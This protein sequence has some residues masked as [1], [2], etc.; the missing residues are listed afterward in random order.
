MQKLILYILIFVA[1][2]GN[3]VAC[4]KKHRNSALKTMKKQIEFQTAYYQFYILDKGIIA[5]KDS[6]D[7]WSESS[8]ANR[9][10]STNSLLAVSTA[11]YGR[12]KAQIN[13]LEQPNNDIDMGSF[14][15]VVEGGILVKSGTIEIA[16]C[17]NQSVEMEVQVPPGNYRI[18]IYSSNLQGVIE[19]NGEDFY[20]IEI[21]PD[22]HMEAKVLKRFSDN[23]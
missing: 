21:W 1:T 7:F 9:L 10:A 17:P 13:L 5:D 12:I 11:S 15:H 8:L 4:M 14:D 18:R 2:F 19:D 23:K 16:D 22:E 3:W 6:N 20:Q